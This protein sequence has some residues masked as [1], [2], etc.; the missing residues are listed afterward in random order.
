[1]IIAILMALAGFGPPAKVDAALVDA[2]VEQ[3]CAQNRHPSRSMVV[4][5]LQIE[6]EVGVAHIARGITAAAACRESGFSPV[7][8]GDWRLRSDHRAKCR[9]GAKGCKAYAVGMFQQWPWTRKGIRSA[10]RDPREDWPNAATHWSRHIVAQ[11][12]RV[13][14]HCK[15]ADELDVWK[16]AHRTAITT[17]AC[18][19]RTASGRCIKWRPRCHVPGRHSSGHWRTRD[20]WLAPAHLARFDD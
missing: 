2:I 13:R 19:K 8:R 3:G 15:Y 20:G 4:A 7:A 17:P 6:L 9:E 1:M 18:A 16:A 5:L 12:R 14:A 10:A 11:V